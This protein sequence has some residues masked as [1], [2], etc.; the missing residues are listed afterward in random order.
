MEPIVLKWEKVEPMFSDDPKYAAFSKYNKVGGVY[1]HFIE[2]DNVKRIITV[3]ETHNDTISGRC[4][5]YFGYKNDLDA[6]KIFNLKLMKGDIYNYLK[7]NENNRKPDGNGTFFIIGGEDYKKGNV[8]IDKTK[9]KSLSLNMAERLYFT[10]V[11]LSEDQA[12]SYDLKYEELT[13][14]VEAI[15]IKHLMK[16]YSV[17]YYQDDHKPPRLNPWLGKIEKD[18]KS[19]TGIEIRNIVNDEESEEWLKDLGDNIYD[20]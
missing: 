8:I 2:N 19:S 5:T 16:N 13:Q 17:G 3:G 18:Y 11:Q 1:L 6:H 12:K 4:N 15:I 9:L 7:D 14:K 10:C 20:V